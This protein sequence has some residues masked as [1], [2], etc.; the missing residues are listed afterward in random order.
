MTSLTLYAKRVIDDISGLAVKSGLKLLHCESCKNV[1]VDKS[2]C[3]FIPFKNKG[4]LTI[5][6]AEVI[7]I[8]KLTEKCYRECVTSNLN[9]LIKKNIPATIVRRALELK[10]F[11]MLKYHVL[12]LDPLDTHIN[13][14]YERANEIREV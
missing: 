8:C 6:S 5:P 11:E 3:P 4:G 14:L 9:V 2:G 10:L 7:M 1:L 12:D 13:G